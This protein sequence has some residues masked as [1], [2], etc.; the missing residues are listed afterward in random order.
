[1]IRPAALA[2]GPRPFVS[3][4]IAEPHLGGRPWSTA[5]AGRARGHSWPIPNL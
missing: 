2:R 1:L 5:P 4:D 3:N